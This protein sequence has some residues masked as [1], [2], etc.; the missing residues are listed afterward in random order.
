MTEVDLDGIKWED[1]RNSDLISFCMEKLRNQ[2]NFHK[3]TIVD[4]IRTGT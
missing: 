2:L 3:E 1:S 4:V